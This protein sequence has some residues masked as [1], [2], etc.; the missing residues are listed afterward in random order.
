[1]ARTRTYT[2]ND[3]RELDKLGRG[4]DGLEFTRHLLDAGEEGRMP[5]ASTIGFRL[6]EVERGRVVLVGEIGEHLYNPIGMV[7]GGVAAT[8]LDSAAGSAVHT[9]VPAG[10]GYT[11]LD[12]TVHYL[13]PITADTGA[14]RAIGTV[15]NR[16]RRTALANAELRDSADRLL[17]HATSS[18]MVFDQP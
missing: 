1:M 6:A 2:W 18:C 14:V 16:G 10:V 12:L 4:M 7:H 9:T 17:A 5:I 3:P 15:L 13:R 11:T 8:L